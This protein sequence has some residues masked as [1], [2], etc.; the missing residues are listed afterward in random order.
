MKN[1]KG[2]EKQLQRNY[3]VPVAGKGEVVGLIAADVY[4]AIKR[5]FRSFSKGVDAIKRPTNA[6]IPTV[7]LPHRWL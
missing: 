3:L 5:L 6:A 1:F 2:I 7:V 4:L